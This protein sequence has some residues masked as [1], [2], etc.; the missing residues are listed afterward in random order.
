MPNLPDIRY[1]QQRAIESRI[2]AAIAR[3]SCA[4][5]AHRKLALAY[6]LLAHPAIDDPVVEGQ[7]RH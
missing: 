7:R 2:A 3:E 4:R 6:D 5:V 1:F